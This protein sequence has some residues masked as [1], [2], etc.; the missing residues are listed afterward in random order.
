MEINEYQK[1]ALSQLMVVPANETFLDYGILG[2]CGESG[3]L[4][5]LVK[6][7]IRDGVWDQDK[8]ISELGD[9]LWYTAFLAK[10]M[11]VTLEEVTV[12]NLLKLEKRAANNAIRGSGNDR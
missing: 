6:K 10:C 11:G 12:N 7:R 5:E 2:L 3:E 1:Q 4:A 9:V 8:A